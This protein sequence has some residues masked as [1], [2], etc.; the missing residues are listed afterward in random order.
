MRPTFQAFM[1]QYELW[2]GSDGE[3]DVRPLGRAAVEHLRGGYLFPELA[4][5]LAAIYFVIVEF[6]YGRLARC[7]AKFMRWT[8]QTFIYRGRPMWNDFYMVLWQLSR[9]PKY[10]CAL[11]QHLLRARKTRNGLQF[12]SGQWM[13]NSV[14]QQDV[15]FAQCWQEAV[16]THGEVF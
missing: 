4:P 5:C 3:G 7:F 1:Q 9:E 11:H 15:E 6:E 14:C 12:V 10:V 8:F 16:R 13:V 2:I